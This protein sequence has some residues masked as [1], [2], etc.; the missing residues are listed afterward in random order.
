VGRVGYVQVQGC[1]EEYIHYIG[2]VSGDYN[3]INGLKAIKRYDRVRVRN[4]G[5]FSKGFRT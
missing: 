5:R 4:R 1:L 2:P 3:Q